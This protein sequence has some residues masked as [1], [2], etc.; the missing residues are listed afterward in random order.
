MSLAISEPTYSEVLDWVKKR[1]VKHSGLRT[2]YDQIEGAYELVFIPGI[3]GS[4][5]RIGSYTFGNDEV[6]C[7]Q[8]VLSQANA[9]A[10]AEV[11]DSF[12]VSALGIAIKKVDV[13]GDGLSLL[14]NAIGGK[15]LHEFAYD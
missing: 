12:I 5:L 11:M 13:Y 9:T 10:T 3:L 2:A 6:D 4:K 15:A 8:L 1:A 7:E 14:Q